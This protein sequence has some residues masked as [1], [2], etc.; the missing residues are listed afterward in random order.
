MALDERRELVESSGDLDVGIEV[1]HVGQLVAGEEVLQEEG[2]DR[3]VALEQRVLEEKR[4]QAGD[5]AEIL[6]LDQGE[7]LFGG[8]EVAVH[9]VDEEH[10]EAALGVVLE[11][12]ARQHPGER[13]VV[14][15]DDG[16]GGERGHRAISR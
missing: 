15:G 4:R 1:D 7:R 12:R 14:L 5:V 13:E 2:L 6:R 10:E 3:R 9:A 11:E 8:I 16:A